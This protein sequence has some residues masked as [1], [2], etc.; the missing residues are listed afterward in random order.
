MGKSKSRNQKK[1]ENMSENRKKYK[2]ERDK[3]KL[4]W[5]KER[6]KEKKQLKK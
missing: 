5:M 3:K 6:G 2:T 4:E 1:L